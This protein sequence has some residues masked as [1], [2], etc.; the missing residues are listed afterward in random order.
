L[1]ASST[2]LLKSSSASSR[3]T[4][5]L[6]R[7][8]MRTV[9]A[10]RRNDD[11]VSAIRPIVCSEEAGDETVRSEDWCGRGNR[12]CIYPEQPPLLEAEPERCI[13][14]MRVTCCQIGF[15]KYPSHPSDPGIIAR[16][17]ARVDSP[18]NGVEAEA[19]RW[20]RENRPSWSNLN[21][22]RRVV[23]L[24]ARSTAPRPA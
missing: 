23:E 3:A 16:E 21:A 4:R 6:T 17:P 2:I 8:L 19:S 11:I 7:V 1:P 22:S 5:F 14:P 10:D 20:L 13:V 9:P 15:R 12:R 24:I 18:D